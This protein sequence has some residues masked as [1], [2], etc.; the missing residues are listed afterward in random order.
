MRIHWHGSLN[1]VQN[2]LGNG[3]LP[4]F[5][6]FYSGQQAAILLYD[7]VLDS[8]TATQPTITASVTQPTITLSVTQPTV[9]ITAKNDIT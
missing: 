9:T 7:V 8:A 2:A 5:N 6:I 3:M 1:A 4:G